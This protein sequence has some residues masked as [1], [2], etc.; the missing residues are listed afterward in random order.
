MRHLTAPFLWFDAFVQKRFDSICFFVMRRFGVRKSAIRY[1]INTVFVLA[2]A[3]GL[4]AR[5]ALGI[6]T[7]FDWF[8][9]G[10][11]LL[12]LLIAQRI[13]VNWDREAEAKPGTA[14]QADRG[15]RSSIGKPIG[16]FF[17]FVDLLTI[18]YLPEEYANRGLT[19]DQLLFPNFCQIALWLSY[20]AWLYLRRTPMNPPPEKVTETVGTSQPSPVQG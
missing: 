20:L 1:A 16:Y 15:G 17:L 18:R 11:F 10:V 13:E 4:V 12:L 19:A 9:G 7:P 8:V 2:V 6:T 14:S 5:T 3:G